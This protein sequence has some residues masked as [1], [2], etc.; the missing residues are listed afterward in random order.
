MRLPISDTRQGL[1]S[2]R[3]SGSH[4]RA[5]RR[6]CRSDCCLRPPRPRRSAGDLAALLGREALPAS[7]PADL[8]ALAPPGAEE[9]SN[10]IKRRLWVRCALRHAVM[11]L[12]PLV[13]CK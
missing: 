6:S 11:L 2:L 4:D 12:P 13:E 9:L 1:V 10:G 5:A 3:H 7:L 8:A